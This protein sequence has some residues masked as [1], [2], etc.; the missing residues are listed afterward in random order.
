ML[1]PRPDL[2]ESIDQPLD[3]PSTKR[4]EERIQQ[5]SRPH[6]TKHPMPLHEKR[7]GSFAG[8]GQCGS[9]AGR[10]AAYDQHVNVGCN[11]C[12]SRRFFNN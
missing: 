8:S 2:V 9:D 5:A 7:L 3:P 12:L 1:T 4:L 6:A 10:A 11:R